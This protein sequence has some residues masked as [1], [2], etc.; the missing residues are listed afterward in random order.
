MLVRETYCNITT[1]AQLEIPRNTF[2][3]ASYFH[4][5]TTTNMANISLEYNA[6]RRAPRTLLMELNGAVFALWKESIA[7]L[8]HI[9][10]LGLVFFN[11]INSSLVQLPLGANEK[12]SQWISFLRA[13]AQVKDAARWLCYQI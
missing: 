5:T 12:E 1:R 2:S 6:Q 8:Q 11:L 4:L 13:F 7:S 10:K 3:N 9:A